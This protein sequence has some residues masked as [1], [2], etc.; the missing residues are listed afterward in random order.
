MSAGK[1]Y[2]GHDCG[3]CV[4][5]LATVN[6]D[7]GLRERAREFYL[8][9]FGRDIPPEEFRCLGGRSDN[10]FGLC[11]ECPFRNCCREKGLEACAECDPPCA[12]YED[13]REK[14]VNKCNQV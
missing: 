13:Y 3:R 7:S 11:R 6:D 14:Y 9:E 12:A 2:C 10:V 1:C 5:Y 4:I 8:N